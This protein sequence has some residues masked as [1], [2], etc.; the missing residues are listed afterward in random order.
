[1]KK[2]PTNIRD[3]YRGVRKKIPPPSRI[4][5]DSRQK[6]QRKEDKKEIGDYLKRG[7]PRKSERE[8]R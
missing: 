7:R 1:M 3:I 2:R 4:E 8:E 6:L 5:P